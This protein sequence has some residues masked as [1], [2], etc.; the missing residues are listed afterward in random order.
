[1]NA[2][3]MFYKTTFQ[4]DMRFTKE[5]VSTSDEKVKKLTRELKIHYI[6]CIGSFIYLLSTRV[7]LSLTV[8]KIETFLTNPG[9]VNFEGLVHLLIYIRENETLGLK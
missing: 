5:D 9:K 4:D 6:D 8:H 3:T 7:D 2:S 1:M